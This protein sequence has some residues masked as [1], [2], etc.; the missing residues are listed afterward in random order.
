LQKNL[1]FIMYNSNIQGYGIDSDKLQSATID[2]LRFP[3]AIMVIFIHMSPGVIN[4]ID[5]DFSSISGHGIYNVIGILLS[6]VLTHIAVP[7][8]YLISG[9]LFFI[10]FQKWSWEGYKKKLN[11]R[12]KTLL[13]PYLLWNVIPFLLAVLAMLVAVSIKGKPMEVV[14]TYIADKN[15]HIFYDCYEWGTT[16]INWLGENLRMTGPYDYPL[17]FLRDLIVVIMMS[18]IIYYAI[19]KSGLFIIGILFVAYISRIWTLLP[20][21]HIT[22]LFYFSTGAYFALNKINIIHFADKYSRLFVTI[23][24][25]LCVATTIYDGENTLIGQNI[26]PLFVCTGVFTAFYVASRCIIKYNI[27]PNKLLVSSCFFV[28][29]IHGVNFPL[30]GSPLSLTSRLLHYAIPGNTSVEKVFCYLTSPF[31]TAFLCV[32]LLMFL[33]QLFPKIT[34]YFSGNK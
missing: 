5:A 17:W 1:P 23:C 33:R 14:E 9:Y 15:W 7:T 20:G 34:L 18:P 30:I 8:F 26:Y 32:L 19:K 2:L 21:F 24:F 6:H 3:L 13:V 29:A 27:R 16:R 22:A 10:N 28:Y 4:L 12:I 25:I 31:V 11:S